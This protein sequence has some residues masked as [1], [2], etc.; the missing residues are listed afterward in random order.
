MVQAMHNGQRM[1][2]AGSDKIQIDGEP[3]VEQ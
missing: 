3:G 2:E 1:E